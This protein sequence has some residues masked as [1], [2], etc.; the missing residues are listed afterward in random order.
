VIANRFSPNDPG[1]AQRFVCWI[2]WQ[3]DRETGERGAHGSMNVY[4]AIAQSCDIYFY[5]VAGGFNQDGEQV[6]ALGIN[7]LAYFAR[8][9]GFGR[10]QGIELPAEAPGNMP[11]EAWKL[12]NIGEPWSTGDD[13][14]TA[15]GQGFVTSTPLQIAQMGAVIANG[16]F[17]YRPTVIHH[18]SD[19]QGRVVVFDSNDNPIFA[20]PGPGGIPI[21]HDASGNRLDPAEVDVNVLFDAQGN[22]VRQPDIVDVLEIDREYIDAIARGMLMTHQING[23]TVGTGTMVAICANDP[24]QFD[25]EGKPIF[26]FWLDLYGISSAGKSG[27]AE[28]C[29]NIAL[30]RGWCREAGEIQPTHSWYVGYAPYEDPE[31]V[32]AAFVFNGEE[33]S[34]YA[35]PV[36]WE[37]MRAWFRVGPYE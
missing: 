23:D 25:E 35:G 17:L 13:Y 28:Y 34:E 9:F 24:C 3:I 32:V 1:R 10:I 20:E 21:L 30:S 36:V 37:V 16:G 26:A 7:Q 19:D 33:G 4:E 22:F 8:Q 6:D 31:I 11:T 12:S 15:I 27:T 2:Y 14:N 5:K 18:F 29:D